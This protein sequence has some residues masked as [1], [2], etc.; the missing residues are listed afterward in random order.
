MRRVAREEQDLIED[1]VILKT[2]LSEN[3]KQ[4]LNHP[5]FPAFVRSGK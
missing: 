3:K 2:K 1:G 4:T 5:W